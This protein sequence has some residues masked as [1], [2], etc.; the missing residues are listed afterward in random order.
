M[1]SQLNQH[2]QTPVTWKDSGGTAVITLASLAASTGMRAGALVDL[3]QNRPPM[4]AWRAWVRFNANPTVGELIPLFLRT[5]N[6]SVPDHDEGTGDIAV[7]AGRERNFVPL[8]SIYVHTAST[9]IKFVRSGGP[10]LLPHRYVSP[11]FQNKSSAA[12]HATAN[13]CG[14]ELIPVPWE[15]Q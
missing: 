9:S 4:F 7:T 11:V 3:G 10:I 15:A 13:E 2:D 8:M 1:A 12:L 5:S 14:F 6:G